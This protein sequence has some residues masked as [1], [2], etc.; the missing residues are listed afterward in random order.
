M[1]NLSLDDPCRNSKYIKLKSRVP[2]LCADFINV[3]PAI[4]QPH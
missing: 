1:A 4:A 3:C 2:E